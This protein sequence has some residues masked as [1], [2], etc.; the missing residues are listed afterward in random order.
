[1]MCWGLQTSDALAQGLHGRT[2]SLLCFLHGKLAL[3]AMSVYH[4][5][6]E[7]AARTPRWGLDNRSI[8]TST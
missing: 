6:E 1:M 4:L 3:H 2:A 8:L 5:Y 7:V